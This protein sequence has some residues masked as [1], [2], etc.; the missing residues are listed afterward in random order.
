M[1]DQRWVVL[2]TDVWSILYS[3]HSR[4][5]RVERWREVLKGCV[6]VIATQSRAEVMTGM[7]Q[8]QWGEARAAS[9]QE[10]LDRT[11]TVP[12]D[13]SVVQAFA[14]LTAECRA[15][16]HAL[17][18]K[19]HTGDRWVAATAIAIDAPLLAGDGI[20][21]NAPGLRLLAESKH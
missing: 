13:E 7:L 18:D 21:E 5:V 20:Y 17:W 3:R 2:D 10:Q 14:T 12:V 4:D 11:A 15:Q 19:K 16:G 8:G 6:I 9:V 1:P